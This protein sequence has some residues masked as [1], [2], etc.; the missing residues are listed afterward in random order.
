VRVIGSGFPATDPAVWFNG[1]PVS[2]AFAGGALLATPPR[3][4]VGP[5]SVSV[6]TTEKPVSSPSVLTI[7]PFAGSP[8]IFRAR[9]SDG[10]APATVSLPLSIDIDVRHTYDVL[11]YPAAGGDGVARPALVTWLQTT[12]AA[13]L[14]GG[15]VIDAALAQA[16]AQG[17]V[18]VESGDP[19]T[20]VEPGS[21]WRI[22][23]AGQ[24]VVISSGGNV[25]T[26]TYGLAA[27]PFVALA[28][29]VDDVPAGAYSIALRVDGPSGVASSVL[30]GRAIALA[31]GDPPPS[32]D[33]PL[34]QSIRAAFAAAGA[35]FGPNARTP[36]PTPAPQW[37]IVDPDGPSLGM[38]L[39]S[40]DG[41][42][43]TT[44]TAFALGPDQ[45][46]VAPIVRIGEN[47]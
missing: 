18:Q 31:G 11:L 5:V 33:A 10:S 16:L 32:D 46:I 17:G 25:L 23:A 26:V 27:D 43:G 6:G 28:C 2:A 40:A 35:T 47:A 24:D 37:M 44:L 36:R 42:G 34:T 3:L 14:D 19:I 1:V 30:R 15:G 7:V 12:Y 4:A 38:L 13:Q 21:A 41:T 22:R 8:V 39:S 20:V 29:A 45:P 9:A